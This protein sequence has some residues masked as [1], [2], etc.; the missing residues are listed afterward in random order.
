MALHFKKDKSRS[1]IIVLPSFVKQIMTGF[2]AIEYDDGATE[3]VEKQNIRLYENLVSKRLEIG[4]IS[5]E[6]L[7]R[8]IVFPP[9]CVLVFRMR[10]RDDAE[11]TKD[12][13]ALWTRRQR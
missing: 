13:L 2:L 9:L 8:T 7:R 3:Y 1:V 5:L 6:P 10:F 11:M 4:T 12:R